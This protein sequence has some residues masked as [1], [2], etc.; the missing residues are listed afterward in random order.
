MTNKI[1]DR[2]SARIW[3]NKYESSAPKAGDFAPDF[4]LSDSEGLI[5]I[6]LS[7]FRAQTPV[8]LIFGSFT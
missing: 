6:K 7:S 2:E 5:S 1:V 8:A 4:E 3:Q